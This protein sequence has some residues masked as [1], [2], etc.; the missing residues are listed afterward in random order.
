MVRS[1]FLDESENLIDFGG[2][3]V[4]TGRYRAVGTKPV[5]DLLQFTLCGVYC[6]MT[7]L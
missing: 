2:E 5:S 3:E 7:S 4:K 1:S 6:F